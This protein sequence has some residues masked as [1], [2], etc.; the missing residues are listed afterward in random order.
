M[1]INMSYTKETFFDVQKINSILEKRKN[2]DESLYLQIKNMNLKCLKTRNRTCTTYG[3]F[4]PHKDLEYYVPKYCGTIVTKTDNIDFKYYF[5]ENDRVILTE[6]YKFPF[7]K[8]E[9]DHYI[10]YFYSKD[11][12][13][14]IFY[15]LKM[16]CITTIKVI[17]CN[18]DKIV[19]ILDANLLPIPSLLRVLN[20][21]K[22]S[23]TYSGNVPT[24]STE[25]YL[26]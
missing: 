8:K 24:V 23:Y 26:L 17:E 5:D 15:D 25:G 19:K 10:F 21:I 6:G 14:C 9:I 2:C 12:I 13:A 1:S 16:K 20:Y 11:N 3:M 18:G 4:L 7:A 22:I